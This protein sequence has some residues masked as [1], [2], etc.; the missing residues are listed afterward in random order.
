M[1]WASPSASVAAAPRATHS[2]ARHSSAAQRR[3]IQVNVALGV[4][5]PQTVRRGRTQ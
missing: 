2:S 1:V 3:A 5:A 4:L